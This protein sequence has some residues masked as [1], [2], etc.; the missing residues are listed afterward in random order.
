ML[1]FLRKTNLIKLE[2]IK[3]KYHQSLLLV[4]LVVKQFNK[5]FEC[6]DS[7]GPFY[8]LGLCK[9]GSTQQEHI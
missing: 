4:L 3:V 1:E 8:E 9:V 2:Q 6:V 5:V 7:A